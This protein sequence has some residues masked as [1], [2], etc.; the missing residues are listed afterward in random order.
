MAIISSLNLVF[1]AKTKGANRNIN[2]LNS[3]IGKMAGTVKLFAAGLAGGLTFRF[4]KSIAD[5]V[6][7]NTK[8]AD[9]LGFAFE[10]FQHWQQLATEAG[11]SNDQ[12][13]TVLRRMTNNVGEAALGLGMAGDAFEFMNIEI[14]ELMKLKPDQ[15]LLA[16]GAALQK[17][18]NQS[19]KVAF[20]RDIFGRA[21]SD[22]LKIF[23]QGTDAI[24][25]NI[26]LFD[27]MGLAISRVDAAR[28]E[29]ANDSLARTSTILGVV[30]KL[31]TGELSDGFTSLN[32]MLLDFVRKEDG[33][34][35][36]RNS[37]VGIAAALS[38]VIFLV[39]IVSN[40]VTLIVRS[41]LL[42][43]TLLGTLL[44]DMVFEF[45]QFAQAL[46]F[47][48]D[49]S[50][51]FFENIKDSGMNAI[52][53]LAF[54]IKGDMD[55]IGNELSGKG[56][57]SKFQDSLKGISQNA[58]DAADRINSSFN[59]TDLPEFMK[60]A[61]DS[62]IT[63]AQKFD[64]SQVDV[65]ALATSGLQTESQKQLFEITKGNVWLER[66]A[67]IL[68]QNKDEGLILGGGI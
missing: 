15:Q 2:R 29:Q 10:S 50:L 32:G 57:G 37:L 3:S 63:F 35:R 9:S 62:K 25:E 19:I 5:S 41:F 40:L 30:A 7:K 56:F 12:F 58:K 65:K 61:M 11:I 22:F 49:R 59:G 18:E 39:R 52:K 27:E 68:G 34:Q 20:A 44:A 17:V 55:D 16:I 1:K 48:Q 47:W 36:I 31:I 26:K 6:D 64:S 54:S 23:E 66:I 46:G 51:K 28:I 60:S 53:E 43:V 67:N 8:F 45:T 13:N 38:P 24:L 42:G 33:I 4:F 14:K 21:G